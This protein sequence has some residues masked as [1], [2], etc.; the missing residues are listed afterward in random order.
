MKTVYR[1]HEIE[2]RRAQCMG[3]WAQL[4]VSVFRLRDGHECTSFHTEDDSTEQ[5]YVGY[6]RDRVDAE[7][8]SD[9]PWGERGQ[10]P[11]L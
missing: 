2:V 8:E 3:G 9:D 7:L 11:T 1:G 6:M 4:Y 5:A 10:N